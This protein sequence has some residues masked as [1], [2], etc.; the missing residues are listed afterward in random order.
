MSRQMNKRKKMDLLNKN[1][2][3][4]ER[5]SSEDL[6]YTEKYEDYPEYS[7]FSETEVIMSWKAPEYEH[8]PKEKNWYTVAGLILS[9]I[10]IY[11]IVINAPIMAIT[12]ILVGIVGYIYL[13]K[14]PE[15]IKFQITHD[16]IIAGKEIY[17]FETIE[18]FWIF[19]DQNSKLVSL[20]TDSWI[21]PYVHIP[22]NDQNPAQIRE[23]LIDFIPES[24]HEPN[25]ID[26]IERIFHI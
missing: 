26:A 10:I 3:K 11:A 7:T 14:E 2:K 12:F 8:F 13:E 20:H 6:I 16:G 18:S 19:Y 17:E 15:I 24:K 25:F 1:K 22:I 21:L 23:I 5:F 9:A 4:K